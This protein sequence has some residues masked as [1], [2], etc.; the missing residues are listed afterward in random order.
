MK[1]EII[2]IGYDIHGQVA[3]FGSVSRQVE[4]AISGSSLSFS[5]KHNEEAWHPRTGTFPPLAG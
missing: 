1:K 4:I 2:R 3:H 5:Q